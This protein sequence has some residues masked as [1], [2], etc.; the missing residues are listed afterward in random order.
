MPIGLPLPTAEPQLFPTTG[1][2][3]SAHL[4]RPVCRATELTLWGPG[5]RP[6]PFPAQPGSAMLRVT[7]ELGKEAGNEGYSGHPVEVK[8]NYR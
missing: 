4:P 3:W 6:D 8:T 1:T 5:V 7:F 2:S